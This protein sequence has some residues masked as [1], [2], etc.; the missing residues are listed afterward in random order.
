MKIALS[1]K[2]L[3]TFRS[4]IVKTN[5]CWLWTG[6]TD[7]KNYGR[8]LLPDTGKLIFAHRLSL[9]LHKKISNTPLI[10]CHKCDNPLCVRPSHLYFGTHRQNMQDASKRCRFPKKRA[11]YAR[12]I[13]FCKRGHLFTDENTYTWKNQRRCISCRKIIQLEYYYRRKNDRNKISAA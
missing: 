5:F 4:R 11:G 6:A 10:A 12:R 8:I 13:T 9:L 2:T 3:S 7:R 1:D